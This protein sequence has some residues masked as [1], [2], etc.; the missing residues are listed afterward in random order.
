MKKNYP[1][2]LIFVICTVFGSC[3]SSKI[4]KELQTKYDDSEQERERLEN[5]NLELNTAITELSSNLNSCRKDV[6]EL[7]GQYKE[8]KED[9]DAKKKDYD[10]LK[11]TCDMLT[12][13]IE[14]LKKGSRADA[15][16]LMKQI[17]ETQDKLQEKEDQL[18][19]LER[20]LSKKEN[21]LTQSLEELNARELRLKELEDILHRKDSLVNAIK[22][23]VANALL[24]FK[25]KGLNVEQKNGKV[26]VSMEE[27]L[28]FASGSW[29]VDQK[30]KEAL[31]Q[32]ATVIQDQKDVEIVIEGHTD[33]VPYK[34]SG[35][36]KDNWDLSVK[37]ATSIVRIITSSSAIDPRQ[38]SA[39]GRSEYLPLDPSDE[40]ESRAKNRRTE[41]II[42]PN[43]D[44]LFGIIEGK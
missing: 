15:K 11:A 24:G 31:T 22:N 28:L 41:I 30:G 44:E 7:Q 35:Q 21:E 12:E 2:S 25:D 33:N 19:L 27:K 34:G 23:K 14:K 4:H 13:N 17:Q 42:T 39:A 32:L 38:L 6:Y 43:L 29:V 26:Y 9:F 3:V 5:E 1:L 16:R 36:I 40:K 37:R 8:A 20:T 10:E 18:R